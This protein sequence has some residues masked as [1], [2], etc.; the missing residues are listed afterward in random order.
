ML[1][2]CQDG[3]DQV[4]LSLKV[5]QILANLELIRLFGGLRGWDP[6]TL[7]LPVNASTGSAG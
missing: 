1:A 7:S 6:S 3:P 5:V 4:G 2:V